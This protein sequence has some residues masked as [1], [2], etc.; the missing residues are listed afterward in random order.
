MI[1][2]RFGKKLPSFELQISI[3]LNNGILAV[4]GPSGAG[5]TTML[6]CIAGLQKPSWGEIQI[7]N[8]L[9]FSSG[10]GMNIH[11]PTK[12]RRIGYV[13]QDYA[14]F[15]HM[16]VEKNVVYGMSKEDNKRSKI[17]SVANVLNMLKIEHL[18]KRYPSQISGG[19]KQRVALARALMTAPEVLLLDESLSALDQ[20][21]RS[22]LQQELRKLQS[23]WQI[24][25]I[26]VTHDIH[27]AE[28]L[29]DQIIRINRGEQET[30]KESIAGL[31]LAENYC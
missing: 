13:F 6:Q 25:F 30:V 10:K 17:L 8:K 15:P 2:A 24:P 14:L 7:G 18:R 12:N 5:K 4:V 29:G 20:D 9:I 11:I 3:A 23:Q 27:E 26:L 31:S 16:T 28:L 1:K 22:T 21:T 19:E